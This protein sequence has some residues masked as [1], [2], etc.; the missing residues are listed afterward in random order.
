M[1]KAPHASVAKPR[2][3]S[4]TAL[5][6]AGA[7]VATLAVLAGLRALLAGQA[8]P[9]PLP[10]GAAAI[11]AAAALGLLV[12]AAPLRWFSRRSPSHGAMEE[13]GDAGDR[14]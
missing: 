5:A 1:S 11:G 2:R 9:S 14:I 8:P 7:A 10:G 3:A 4:M 13:G 12:L 6:A